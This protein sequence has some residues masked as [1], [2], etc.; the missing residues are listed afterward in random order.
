[1]ADFGHHLRHRQ[2]FD[3][4]Q[5]R[6]SGVHQQ[7]D[8]Q[9]MAIDS[10]VHGKLLFPECSANNAP[11]PMAE[12]SLSMP[13]LP[14]AYQALASGRFAEVLVWSE[15]VQATDT[16]ALSWK[17]L[18][19]VALS[20][21][22]RPQEALPEYQWLCAHEPGNPAHWSNLGNCLCEL[23]REHEALEP[24]QKAQLLG[25]TEI[26]LHFGLARAYA[27]DSQ[28]ELARRHIETAITH[29]PDDIEFMLLHLR[30]LQAQDCWPEA[31]RLAER[32][33]NLPLA[34]G[35]RI[36][37]GYLLFHGQW[38]D[39]A[40]AHFSP[41]VIDPD[42]AIDARIG[43]IMAY[44]RTNRIIQA[45]AL[46]ATMDE[47]AVCHHPKLLDNFL[48]M[49]AKMAMRRK[50]YPAARALS[51]RILMAAH[52]DP[53]LRLGLQF[54]YAAALDKCGDHDAA[55]TVLQTAHALRRRLVNRSHPA[56]QDRIQAFTVLE[57]PAPHWNPAVHIH[58]AHA[59]PVFVVGF[60]RSGTTLLEQLLDAHPELVSFDEQP[61]LQNLLG[62]IGGDDE[63]VCQ[64][65]NSLTPEQTASGRSA[66]FA[67]VAGVVP[68]I[69]RQRA[70]DKNPL[71]MVRL[72][73]LQNFFPRSRI[74]LAVRHPCDV[75]LSCYMQNFRAPAFA[76]TFETLESTAHMYDRVF[77]HWYAAAA[78]LQLPVL[79][80]KYEDL[81]AN[82]EGRA[83]VLFDFL[84][85]PWQDSL[86]A[87]TERA[88]DKGVIKT[89]SYT[90]VVQPVNARA[91]GRWL[92][93]EAY[94]TP[95]VMAHLTPWIARFGY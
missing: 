77:A 22:Q 29:D 92:A 31:L 48:Q 56:L 38:Y 37:L 81:V 16:S 91:V 90:Q 15:C 19:A 68:T 47:S 18:R 87:F 58:D 52:A 41:P 83:R 10:R 42:L 85:L 66:Y 49:Q 3:L 5:A 13:S 46:Q 6:I 71:N 33:Q 69:D 57:Q 54:E 89:P 43:L 27:A 36:D 30:I 14:E 70:V 67:E 17:A 82:T 26:A 76:L 64:L 51:E 25:A 59:D 23:D 84:Q 73:L 63:D 12:A 9:Y 8:A 79:I 45:E 95:A 24:L 74:I 78:A 88:K 93:Y 80:W 1:V 35:Q 61:F 2:L 7:D 53:V 62:Q 11:F 32:L 72:P 39:Q 4:G 65:I 86:L 60:P 20:L 34:E 44:E 28:L 50:D 94:F 55:M 75:V 21:S 40:I